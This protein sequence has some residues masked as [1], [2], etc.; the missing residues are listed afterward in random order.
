MEEEAGKKQAM[1]EETSRKQA[2]EKEVGGSCDHQ[3][4]LAIKS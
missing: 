2:M 3:R 4:G 1:E